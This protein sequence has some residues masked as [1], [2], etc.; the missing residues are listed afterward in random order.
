MY[1]LLD[2][3]GKQYKAVKGKD[4]EVDL[5]HREEGE[6]IEFD[7]VLMLQDDDK[8]ILGTP[9]VEGAKIKASVGTVRKE[10]KILVFKYK[11]RKGY[12]KTRGHRQ[13]Y[14]TLTIDDII[15]PKG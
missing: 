7:T 13:Q 8:T 10:K 1:A 14:L 3:R 12:R 11:R 2:I 6:K 15:R 4:I 9:Y 5:L